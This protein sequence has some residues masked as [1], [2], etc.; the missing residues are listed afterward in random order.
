MKHCNQCNRDES[1]EEFYNT[2]RTICKKCKLKNNKK[3]YET[4]ADY[5]RPTDSDYTVWTGQEYSQIYMK[6]KDTLILD[7]N[8]SEYIYKGETLTKKRLDETYD[9]KTMWEISYL[10]DF[11]VVTCSTD[12]QNFAKLYFEDLWILLSDKS[13]YEKL[14]T[15]NREFHQGYELQKLMGNI[16]QGN[17]SL[18]KTYEYD[19]IDKTTN[20]YKKYSK[21]C[22]DCGRSMWYRT[23]SAVTQS[24]SNNITCSQCN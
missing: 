13:E 6:D 23:Q 11:G 19:L 14:H 24:E 18:T 21:R 20:L 2:D 10:M 4:D 8:E 16:E 3:A 1:Q 7:E 15:V 17:S 12:I 9:F 5:I 22:P